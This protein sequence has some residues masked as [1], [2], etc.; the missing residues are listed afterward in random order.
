MVTNAYAIPLG[1]PH[2]GWNFLGWI[3]LVP[4]LTALMG[5]CPLYS[6]AGVSTC[7]RN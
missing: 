6:L 5:S 7:S 4:L 2:T 1:F 3:G